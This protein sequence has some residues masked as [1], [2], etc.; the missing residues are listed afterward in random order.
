MRATGSVDELF[1]DPQVE[2]RGGIGFGMELGAEGEPIV[3]LA[4]DRFDDAVR[5]AGG[6][7]KARS[8]TSSTAMWCMLLTRISPSP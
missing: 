8:A 3:D 7:G 2:R 1:E 4:F 6:D 5:A